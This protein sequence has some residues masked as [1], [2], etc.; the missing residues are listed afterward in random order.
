MKGTGIKLSLR[1]RL[2]AAEAHS[3]QAG[4]LTGTCSVTHPVF[5][6]GDGDSW[7]STTHSAPAGETFSSPSSSTAH[8]ELTEETGMGFVQSAPHPDCKSCAEPVFI[9]AWCMC[10]CPLRSA[11][12]ESWIW[13]FPWDLPHPSPLS[14][15][16]H[17]GP[18]RG[19]GSILESSPFMKSSASPQL[20]STF[21]LFAS[22]PVL[23]K[24]TLC[25][26]LRVQKVKA[27]HFNL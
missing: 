18:S 16:P 19:R 13:A 6:A 2:V 14:S 7:W 26:I 8:G 11:L 9:T 23:T 25:C 1:W 24:F 17:L 10:K 21:H 22:M 5:G 15:C 3:R 4:C 12:Q 20:P 27:L